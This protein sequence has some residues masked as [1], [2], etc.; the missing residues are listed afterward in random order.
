MS[1]IICVTNRALCAGDF[2]KRIERIAATHPAAIVLREKELTPDAYQELA[3][4]VLRIC[5]SYEVP[6]ILHSFAEVA[7]KLA[8]EALQLPLPALRELSSDM[9]KKLRILGTSCHSV[10]DALEA[11]RLGCTYLIAGHIYATDCKKGLPGRG[12]GFLREVCERVS[13]P[14]YA[15]GGITP[16]N[17]KEVRRIGAAGACVMSGLMQCENVENYMRELLR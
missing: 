9:K 15:I 7:E 5:K 4:Q 13:I 14:V 12:I 6:C 10:Q 1:D 2:L 16:E 17:I 3:E 11:E 8:A